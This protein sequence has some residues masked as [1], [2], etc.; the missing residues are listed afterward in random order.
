MREE[1]LTLQVYL[2]GFHEV[3][4]HTGDACMILFHGTAGGPYFTGDILP[5]GVDTQKTLGDA[6]RALSARY[7]L[8]GHDRTG[9]A[10]R[11]FI[12]NNGI[13]DPET[14]AIKTRPMILTD[15]EDLAFLEE[16]DLAGTVENTEER[17][18]I[19]IRI[20]R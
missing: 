5:G 12:E 18:R 20:F 10:C 16:T 2:D 6:P 13:I 19:V 9:A 1:V 14:G 15:S 8:D 11:I 17:G 3:K 4:G 7:V